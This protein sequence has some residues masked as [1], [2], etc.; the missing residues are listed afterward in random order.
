MGDFNEWYR[1]TST[2]PIVWHVMPLVT[3]KLH[4]G[5]ILVLTLAAGWH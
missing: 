5:V 4:R 3:E 1:F 2:G